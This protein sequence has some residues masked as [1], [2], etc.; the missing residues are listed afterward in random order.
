MVI[1]T[2]TERLRTMLRQTLDEQTQ[3]EAAAAGP[4]GEKP[5]FTGPWN[6]LF[7]EHSTWD[8]AQQLNPALYKDLRCQFDDNLVRE[9]LLAAADIKISRTG[10]KEGKLLLLRA[11]AER[12]GFHIATGDS[13]WSPCADRGKGGWANRMTRLG[14]AA[15]SNGLR[16]VYIA[17]DTAL[18]ET[19]R[20]LDE[21]G[22]DD[23]FGA[24]LGIPPCCRAMFDEYKHL[25]AEKQ[26]DFVPF[27]LDSTMD[28]MPFDWRLNYTA[29]YFGGSLLSFFPCS[30]CCPAAVAV[31]D[32]TLRLLAGCD[33]AWSR[34]F[35]ELQQS[36]VLYTENSGLHLFRARLSDGVIAYEP[37]D[38]KSTEENELA[39]LLQ[40]GDRLAV[41]GKH[42][43]EVYRGSTPIRKLA[44]E[45][46][47]MCT[48][49]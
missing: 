31:A 27:V 46:L 30:F 28:T 6:A 35:V 14:E 26:Y 12:H 47:C 38:L 48:F 18:A 32:K 43:V 21:A 42:A 40:Y 11:A 9:I 15:E 19:G 4:S 41:I 34:R 7:E 2:N 36:N 10:M 23:L 29:Q 37:Q 44:G 33:P 17:S 24:L 49:F 13:Q 25:A 1:Q 39:E 45:D 22:Q 3:A 20:M 5:L 16:T 8:S